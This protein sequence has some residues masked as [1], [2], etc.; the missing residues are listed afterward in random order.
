MNPRSTIG[1]RGLFAGVHRSMVAAA[2]GLISHFDFSEINKTQSRKFREHLE[3][4]QSGGG[5][6]LLLNR[7]SSGATTR[8]H[9]ITA[10]F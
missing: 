1:S 7:P 5:K 2:I 4:R 6:R 10:R 9:R 3:R 8:A